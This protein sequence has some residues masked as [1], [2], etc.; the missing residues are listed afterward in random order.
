MEFNQVQQGQIDVS[1]IVVSY[2]T[3]EMTL[4]ALR[5]VYRETNES[6]FELIVVDNA[7]SDGSAEAIANEFPDVR[8]MAETENHG[9]ARA[10]NLAARYAVGQY[11]LLLNPDTVVLDKAID[12]LIAFARSRPQSGIWGGRTLFGD[13]SL[14]PTSCWRRMTLWNVFCRVSGLARIFRKSGFFNSEAYGN[15][16]RDSVRE[17]DIVTGCFF[18]IT[19]KLWEE[20]G[21][22]SPEFFMYGEEADMCLRA[23][24]L[25]V[26]PAVTPEATIIHYGGASE[27]VRADKM[28]RIMRA[29][30]HLMY[31][32][33]SRPKFYLG[34]WLYY[35]WVYSR[36]FFY[37]LVKSSGAEGAGGE[38]YDAW[39]SL[40]RARSIWA[41]GFRVV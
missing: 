18:L 28:V 4:E 19:R 34:L 12:R 13:R 11:L 25:G 20:L 37:K 22:F 14:N 5:S 40:W 6:C 17:V 10:N 29:K 2:N 30:V 21:G 15:W 31:C 39:R 8:V 16:P 27:K 33:W 9:F 1:I 35:I 36:V 7:S 23:R 26:R 32:H 38:D 41:R 3:C 24:R